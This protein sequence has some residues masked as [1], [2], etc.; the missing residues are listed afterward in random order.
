MLADHRIASG[1]PNSARSSA[2]EALADLHVEA[3]GGDIAKSLAGVPAGKSTL[4]SLDA[5][6]AVA[7]GD[8]SPDADRTE[9][10]F[11]PRS[12]SVRS[13]DHTTRDRL[14]QLPLLRSMVR[15]GRKPA[16]LR[17]SVGST[18][19]AKDVV[20]RFGRIDRSNLGSTGFDVV[21]PTHA[22]GK[23]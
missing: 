21:G 22:S 15:S 14:A 19:A 5:R 20:A 9:N 17:A 7:M 8:R 12:R 6:Q 18:E 2:I 16:S 13:H 3:H 4:E 11:D 10:A 1:H 23:T